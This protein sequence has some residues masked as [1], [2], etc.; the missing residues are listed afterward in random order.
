M[1]TIRLQRIGKTK[2]ATYRLVVS[3]KARDTQD[4]CLEN[5]G[6][7]N[8]HAKEN[9]A[10]FNVDRVKYWIGKGAQTS[11]TVNNLLV[12][13]KIIEGKKMKSVF[14][15]GKRKAKIAEKNKGKEQ[16][17]PAS[18]APVAE[19]APVTPPAAV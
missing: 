6:T 2:V 18:A 9:G 13:N 19:A 15:S 8:P 7:F 14:L 16:A 1:L 3:E 12:T 4:I 10:Q 11:E 17:A 5:L